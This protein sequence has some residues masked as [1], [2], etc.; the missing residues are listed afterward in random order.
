MRQIERIQVSKESLANIIELIKETVKPKSA[1]G[2]EYTNDGITGFIVQSNNVVMHKADGSL[3]CW[4][5]K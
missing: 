4:Y 2:Y 3:K 1:G 5:A